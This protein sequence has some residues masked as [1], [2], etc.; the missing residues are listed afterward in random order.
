MET[1]VVEICIAATGTMADFML[2][3]HIPVSKLTAELVPLI[4]QAYQEVYFGQEMPV[5]CDM[6]S[7]RISPENLTLAQAGVRDSQ[8]LLIV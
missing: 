3:A 2:P 7:R 8:R 4:E 6:T 5:L 1:I